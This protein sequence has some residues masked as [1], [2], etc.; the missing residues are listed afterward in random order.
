[1]TP[2]PFYVNAK[3]KM[4]EESR[5][6]ISRRGKVVAVYIISRET[7]IFLPLSRVMNKRL[8]VGQTVEIQQYMLPKEHK[9]FPFNWL[10]EVENVRRPI[11]RL[12]IKVKE[13]EL[14]IERTYNDIVKVKK[15]VFQ[16][17]RMKVN[18][19]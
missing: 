14:I 2:D 16:G 17:K 13:K 7:I 10:I 11:V 4:K 12:P 9:Y 6:N 19:L 15:N 18:N 8:K 1:M 5:T 3:V